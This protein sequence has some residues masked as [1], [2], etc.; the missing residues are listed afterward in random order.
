MEAK[1]RILDPYFVRSDFGWMGLNGRPHHVN[2]WNPWINSNVLTANLLLEK[3]AERRQAVVEI[4]TA[5][6]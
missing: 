5:L 6:P 4:A 2:N 1:R 3:D